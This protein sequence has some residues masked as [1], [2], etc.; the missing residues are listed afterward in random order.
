M[1][2]FML[3]AAS[4]QK[5]VTIGSNGSRLTVLKLMPDGSTNRREQELPSEAAAKSAGEKLAQ[6]LLARG[7]VEQ[8]SDAAKSTK[9]A[10]PVAKPAQRS[11]DVEDDPGPLYDLTEEATDAPKLV[12]PRVALAAE[13][14]KPAPKK[15]KKRDCSKE[16]GVSSLFRELDAV[17]WPSPAAE[18]LA[19]PVAYQGRFGVAETPVGVS[20]RP[21]FASYGDGG[22]SAPR[23]W[24]SKAAVCRP[25]T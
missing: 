3:G 20:D 7:Y 22:Y 24:T 13:S 16:S 8:R 12:L 10:K 19:C 5:V 1:R 6:E 11:L 14:A 15:K 18:R 9:P 25:G 2:R 23:R 4:E 21:S 17:K